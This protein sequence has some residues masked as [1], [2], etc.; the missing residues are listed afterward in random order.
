ML[1][2]LPATD[3]QSLTN[4]IFLLGAY[5]IIHLAADLIAIL[6]NMDPVIRLIEPY[7]NS[8]RGE[9]V[10]NLL[11]QDCW[12]G[13]IRARENGWADFGPEGFDVDEYDELDSILNADLHQVSCFIQFFK[14]RCYVTLL[15]CLMFANLRR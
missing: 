12:K 4:K 15:K 9:Q 7:R 2:V 3:P 6:R 14:L 1:V 13:L 8:A 5:M 10:F 11:V